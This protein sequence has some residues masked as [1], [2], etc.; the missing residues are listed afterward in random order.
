ME[1]V[2]ETMSYKELYETLLQEHRQV[3]EAQEESELEAF[4]QEVMLAKAGFPA[5]A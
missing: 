4:M 5:D 2:K 3:F 1:G